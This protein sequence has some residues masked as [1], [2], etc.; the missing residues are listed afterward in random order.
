MTDHS[1]HAKDPGGTSVLLLNQYYAPDEAATA[2]MLAD[3]G[4]GLAARGFRV[5]ALASNRSYIDPN[6]TYPKHDTIDGVAI[7]RVA[8]SGFGRR[9]LLGRL[10][11]YLTFVTG[12]K[13]A[14]LLG[15]RPDVVIVLTTPPFI[16]FLATFLGRLRGIRTIFWSMDVYPDVAFATGTLRPRGVPGLL[17]KALAR[18]TVRSADAVVALGETMARHLA[19]TPARRI[20]VIH[21]WADGE[22]I[23]PVSRDVGL[24]PAEDR[25]FVA[26]Y[27]GNMGLAHEFV[28]ILGIAGRLE[29]DPVRF[30]FV[31]GGPR[32]DEIEGSAA[33]LRAGTVEL[34]PSVARAD[35]GASLA[36]ADLHLVS[37]R[38]G[39]AGLLVPS[40]IYGI[41]ASGRPVLY[42]GPAAGEVYEIIRE[43]DCG[44]CVL[45]GDVDAGVAAIRAYVAAPERGVAEGRR[46]RQLFEERFSRSRGIAQWTKLVEDVLKPR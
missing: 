5:R 26:M 34:R 28:T 25:P 43:G 19:R 1:L 31:G 20:E 30:V 35:L 14:L 8:T 9:S 7:R 42:V 3:L 38:D 37:L 18:R 45:P 36:S 4:A 41:L 23:R 15:E 13:R 17:G 29:A 6:R 33:A 10:A 46:G 39:M 2:Q 44:T 27:S 24:R 22:A 16:A 21:N 11:D 12:A 32:R 40:K